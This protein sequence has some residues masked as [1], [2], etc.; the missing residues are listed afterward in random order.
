MRVRMLVSML[1]LEPF[2][3]SYPYLLLA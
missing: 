1:K 2:I 3:I